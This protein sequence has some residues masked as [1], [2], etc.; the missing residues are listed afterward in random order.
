MIVSFDANFWH[1]Q[2][3]FPAVV[4]GV[5]SDNDTKICMQKMKVKTKNKSLEIVSFMKRKSTHL[6]SIT[7]VFA[8]PVTDAFDN[9]ELMLTGPS[10]WNILIRFNFIGSMVSKA[11]K[12]SMPIAKYLDFWV[13]RNQPIEEKTNKQQLEFIYATHLLSIA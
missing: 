3:C 9:D 11:V 5:N 7:S 10:P 6:L 1:H 4:N 13:K 8:N 12:P 2:M